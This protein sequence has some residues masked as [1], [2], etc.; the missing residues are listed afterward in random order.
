M[1]REL[2][3]GL[4]LKMKDDHLNSLPDVRKWLD[5]VAR[6]IKDKMHEELTA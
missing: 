2:I 3:E 5:E 1:T 4:E 6:I